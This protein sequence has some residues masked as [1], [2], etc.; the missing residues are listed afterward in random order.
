MR[1]A[2]AKVMTAERRPAIAPALL[3][4]VFDGH[5]DAMLLFDGDRLVS[6]NLRLFQLFPAL[7]DDL[8]AGDSL[9]IVS[10]RLDALEEGDISRHTRLLGDG[11]LLLSLR[12]SRRGARRSRF[13]G[14]DRQH[15]RGIIDPAGEFDGFRRISRGAMVHNDKDRDGERIQRH[16]L[17]AV[18]Y[19]THGLVIFDAA[20]RLVLCNERFRQFFPQVLAKQGAATTYQEFV[21]SLAEGWMSDPGAIGQWV[22]EHVDRHRLGLTHECQ[23]LDGR[24]FLVRDLRL[25]D[26]STVLTGTDITGLKRRETALRESEARFRAIFQHAAVG[27]AVIRSGGRIV[28]TNPALDSMLGY[29]VC[30]LTA[31]RYGDLV[32]PDDLETEARLAR[33]LLD[34]EIDCFRHEARYLHKSGRYVWGRL[35]VSLVRGLGDDSFGVAMIEN[36][37]ERKK[38]ETDLMTFRAVAE[39]AAEA[40]VI[41]SLDGTPFYVNPAYEKLFGPCGNGELP[42]HYWDHYTEDA[43]RTI[44]QIVLPLLERGQGWEGILKAAVGR[45]IFPIWQRAGTVFDGMGRAQFHFVFMHDHSNQQQIRDELC[46]AKELAEQANI[47]KTRFL[48]A[49]SHD[50]RQPLQALSMFVAVLASRSH[51][52]EDALLIQRIDDSVGA[53]ETLLNGLLDVSKLEAGLVVPAPASFD[54]A[55]LLSRLASEFQPLAAEVGLGFHLV[56]SHAVVRSDPALLERILRNLLNNAVR[57]TKNGRVLLGCR[58]RRDTMV[59]EVW[60]TG[61]GIPQNQLKLIFREFHQLGN[62]ARDR[63]Q[64]LGLGLA[65]VDRLAQ[66]LDHRIDVASEP[67]RG[68][69]FSVEVPLAK[70]PAITPLQ[71]RQAPL[72]SRRYDATILI[73]EDEPDVLESTC[74]LLES[75]GFNVLSAKDCDEAL[76][77][78]SEWP[79]KPDL[80]LADY[81]L[82]SGTTGVQAVN[83][84]RARLKIALPAIILTGDTAPERLRQAKASGHGLLHKPV[85][86]VMLH[87]MIDE[88]L[89]MS[90]S[91]RERSSAG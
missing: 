66:L 3:A 32:H 33:R 53:V 56:T 16:L 44:R 77:R 91:D 15:W 89:S 85:Q 18:E 90:L 68:S 87:R 23:A 28:Q 14:A 5:S 12:R 38:A 19:L 49:A 60:D 61:I 34:G 26:G 27:V 46:K 22:D 41:L 45:R 17:D 13:S 10:A 62:S 55:P 6:W 75:W 64:G 59:I 37:D 20:G 84:I 43:Q 40:I 63:R 2:V 88:A 74:L 31:M 36:I 71:P 80:I 30:E 76:R 29:G 67:Q 51:S 79:A 72:A 35:T 4:A 81:R 52:P 86:P 70:V 65:I 50:L 78:M 25:P 83:L 48:A 82:Q 21:R 42:H 47:A 69:V 57:Y 1:N 54:I 11:L 9:E 24:W 73:I 58:R 39:A 7:V 8:A